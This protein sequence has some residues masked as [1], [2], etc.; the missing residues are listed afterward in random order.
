MPGRGAAKC[1]WVGSEE[2]GL[3][4][5][6]AAKKVTVALTMQTHRSHSS[7]C[8]GALPFVPLPA[9]SDAT[10]D[11]RAVEG[12]LPRV[13]RSSDASQKRAWGGGRQQQ[14][15]AD[16]RARGLGAGMGAEGRRG[17]GI[18]LALAL[19]RAPNSM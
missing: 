3:P 12:P 16:A 10:R 7:S 11:S 1:L 14:S 2:Q 18:R 17:D 4:G 15:E 5:R 9:T 19:A 13:A 8:E 6:G